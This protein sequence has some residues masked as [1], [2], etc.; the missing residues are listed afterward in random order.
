MQC[1]EFGK[2]HSLGVKDDLIIFFK[3]TIQVKKVFGQNLP[4]DEVMTFYM[5]KVNG[6]LHCDDIM[7]PV[8][9]Y[10]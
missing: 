2:K 8:I 3:V 5:Q 10:H 4:H 1:K 6:H 9:Q 7:L